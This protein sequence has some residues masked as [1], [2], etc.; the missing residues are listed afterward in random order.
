M[1]LALLA[2]AVSAQV[3]PGEEALQVQY[4]P[5]AYTA[6][7]AVTDLV[8]ADIDHD[9]DVDVL[10]ADGTAGVI[11]VLVNAGAQGFFP[12]TINTGVTPSVLAI[13]DLDS[14]GY[15]DLVV[16]FNSGMRWMRNDGAGNYSVAATYLFPAGDTDPVAARLADVNED[17]NLDAV[18]GLNSHQGAGGAVGGLWIALGDGA[19]GFQPLATQD[20]ALRAANITIADFNGD[21][22][23]DVAELSGQP[24]ISSAVTIVFGL[25]DG[26]FANAG[27]G[28]GAGIYAHGLASGD[29]DGDGDVD[30]ATGFKY[31][32]SVR[33]ND[34]NGN[35]TLAQ[36]VGVGS[37]VKGITVGDIDRDG[38]LDIVAT[39]GTAKALRLM[40]NDTTGH[41][42]YFGQV[43]VSI[44]C[45]S[46]LLADT[47]NDGYLDAWAGDAQTGELFSGA[48]HCIVARY[49]KG[50]LNSLGVLP[51]MT[52][53]GVP[54]ISGE[55][56]IPEGTRLL[57]LQPAVFVVGTDASVRPALGGL[58]LVQEPWFLVPTKTSAG[59]GNP[60]Q[61]DGT[62]T[63]PVGAEQLGGAGVGTKFFIQVLALDP[64][65]VDG[66]LASLSDGLWFEIVL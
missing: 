14:D 33:M 52:A 22:H 1:G 65:Q 12:R 21:G 44:Q 19:G 25:G 38:D 18:L 11:R 53:T 27:P 32:V 10:S 23:L 63:L 58:L 51:A 24:F 7:S 43:P 62:V 48:S 31:W 50:K 26:S 47:N 6:G 35:F 37:Y 61:S 13:G 40:A 66:T 59:S 60:S 2:G 64:L 56:F 8:S 34:G 17:G 30:I 42:T 45:F 49:G 3:L 5:S 15:P 54:S 4:T 41:F 28:F 20:L 55:G 29:F 16:G 39:S 36:S 57:P 9:G 46:V